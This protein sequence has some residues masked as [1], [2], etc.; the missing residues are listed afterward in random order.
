M[1]KTKMDLLIIVIIV[2]MLI[3]GISCIQKSRDLNEYMEGKRYDL[4]FD[5]RTTDFNSSSGEVIPIHGFAFYYDFTNKRGSI[6]FDLHKN[7]SIDYILIGFPTVVDNNS[8]KIY[9]KEPHTNKNENKMC[10]NLTKDYRESTGYQIGDNHTK[11]ILDD[12]DRTFHDETFVIEFKSEDLKPKGVFTFI[13]IDQ[14]FIYSGSE[15]ANVNFILGDDYEC[16]GSCVSKLQNIE[17][18]VYSFDRDLQLD[19]KREKAS[20]TCAFQLDTVSRKILFQKS[21]LFGL[22]LLFLGLAITFGLDIWFK[23]IKEKDF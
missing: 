8:L 7:W 6:S 14:N 4:R 23:R 3:G 11:L 17:E 19:F 9:T 10:I 21:F 22:G 18:T 5:L 15:T 1:K 12:F 2:A 13:G 20:D 16:R